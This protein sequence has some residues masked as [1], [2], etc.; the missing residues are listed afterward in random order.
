M[1]SSVSLNGGE[2]TR[3][4]YDTAPSYRAEPQKWLEHLR[5]MAGLTSYIEFKDLRRSD[6]RHLLVS[7][8]GFHL[9]SDGTLDTAIKEQTANDDVLDREPI[10]DYEQV[11][12]V[13]GHTP[14]PDGP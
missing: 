9:S 1:I 6:G 13:I 3:Q 5:W 4:S 14:I 7:H 12:Q 2:Q 10:H 11:F 8:A